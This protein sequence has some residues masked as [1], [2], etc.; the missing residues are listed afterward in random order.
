[1]LTT[2]RN[3]IEQVLKEAD[4]A[5]AL[6]LL[7]LKTRDALGVDCC[8]VYLSDESRK[9][10]RLVATDGLLKE[11]I[12][13]VILRYGEG[14][15]GLVGKSNA[16]LNLANAQE[17][18]NFK[19]I[20]E[21]GEEEFNSFLG[22]PITHEGALLGVLI[23]Q[24]KQSRQ[25]NEVEESFMVTLAAQL[26]SILYLSEQKDKNTDIKAPLSCSYG[27]G[28]I[29]IARSW[30]WQ[31]H[32]ELEHVLL[33][34]T[35][36]SQLQ[37]EL[38]H[39]ALLQLQLDLDAL[40]LKVHDNFKGIDISKL[41]ETYQRI[42]D[43]NDFSDNVDSL[44]YNENWTAS[45][46]VKLHSDKM[47]AQ[48]GEH[49][50]EEAVN[51]RDLAQRLLSRLAHSYLEEFDFT[52]PVVLLAEEISASLI[53]EIPREKIA[54]IVSLKGSVNSTAAILAK[55]LNI[56]TL[57]G[58]E[59]QLEHLD[60]HLFILDGSRKELFID[61]AAGVLAEYNGMITD[62]QEYSRLFNAEKN[63]EVI[64]LDN[65]RIFVELNAGLNFDAD[66]QYLIDMIDGVGLYRTE[67]EYMMY[68]NFPSELEECVHY[69]DCLTH[70]A[71]K[72]V[73]MRT[74]DIGGD[75]PLPYLPLHEDNP[76]LGWRGIR[77]SL[78]RPELLLTQF[79][80][81]LK[82]SRKHENLEIMLPMISNLDEVIEAKAVLDRAYKEVCEEISTKI[83][84]PKLGAMIEVPA[85]MF[86]LEDLAPYLDF[87]SI[88]SNDLTQYVLAVDRNNT[89]VSK[90][91]DCFQPAM[92]RVLARL[93]RICNNEINRPLA[94]CGELA[95]DPLGAMLLVSIGYR[96]LS[97]NYTSIPMIKYILRRVNISELEEIFRQAIKLSSAEKIKE[98]YLN[99]AKE[100]GVDFYIKKLSAL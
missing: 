14:L 22:V 79:R 94:I 9:R 43:D 87:F 76:F 89:N 98:L 47:I 5:K 6:D 3:I 15:V 45:S 62:N 12:G 77:I 27:F 65:Q 41:F 60:R 88:G 85:I 36:D 19:Y 38:F 100:K 51:I 10:Y 78:D 20:P 7:V 39:Q 31:P 55:N 44:I 56:P 59:I 29:A 35:N 72:R 83:A 2:L 66:D 50:K 92:I 52:E 24:Q 91:Y 68:T 69:E 71:P 48:L 74:L 46:A 13:K 67:I 16:V 58:V 57:I 63:K 30:V 95:A 54:G 21:I 96:E 23:A 81:M 11:S 73:R 61:P 99:Y 80:A 4:I 40:S 49:Q 75:K 32:M 64:T 90:L 1:L 82:A 84:Y 42:L 53:A 70:F 18:P 34:K 93:F 25:F 86:L 97:M 28:G 37:V 26:S 8:S 17:H 33:K